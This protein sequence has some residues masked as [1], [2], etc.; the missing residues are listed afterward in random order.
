[1]WDVEAIKSAVVAAVVAFAGSTV[2]YQL[3]RIGIKKLVEKL[4]GA[5]V[6][7]KNQNILTQ[8]QSD[9]LIGEMVERESQL[10]DKVGE[11]LDKLPEADAIHRIDVYFNGI[12]DKID[13][14]LDEIESDDE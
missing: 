8:E 13:A 14:F 1:M 12:A 7:L 3:I 6:E 4:T 2:F 11:I 5:V 10:L 9:K